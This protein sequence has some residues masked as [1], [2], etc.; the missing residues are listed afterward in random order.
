MNAPQN[1]AAGTA[2]RLDDLTLGY[3]RHPAVH[4]LSAAIPDG[5]LVAVIGPNGAG[6]STLLKA[7]AGALAPLGG[8]VET[9]A[10]AGARIAYLPQ[11]AAI[12]RSFPISVFD[13]V[14]AGLWRRTGLFGALSAHDRKAVESAL[15]KVGLVG[16]ER[17]TIDALSGGQL[18]RA[19]FARLYLQDARIVL[20]DEPLAAIDTRTSAD[21][22]AIIN[23]WHHEG[24][25][26]LA[27]LHDMGIVR[28]HF[29]S[30]LLLARE[31]VAFG[32]TRHV[33]TSENLANARRMIE[34]FDEEA[35]VCAQ[36]GAR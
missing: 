30:A 13:L 29:P 36:D 8:R 25:T 32:E 26:V 21:L 11:L 34:A 27:V 15:E 4:H 3:D 12:D 31:L 17:R 23:D 5:S 20:L 18:Q 24:R 2:I 19:L 16:F 22:L 28:H 6:K 35:H 14:A 9:G 10:K 1:V 33:L 7:I